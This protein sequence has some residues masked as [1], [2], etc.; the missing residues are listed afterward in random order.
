MRVDPPA[1]RRARGFTLTEI[2]VAVAILA[3]LLGGLL[4]PL[5]TQLEA[6]RTRDTQRLLEAAREAIVGFAVANG[7]LPCPARP[8]TAVGV[9]G[10]GTEEVT[11]TSPNRR[12][13]V[14]LVDVSSPERAVGVLPWVTLGLPEADA[15]GRRFTYVVD[16]GFADETS[17]GCNPIPN[18][19]SF[20]AQ[21]N[22]PDAGLE[23][24]TRQGL[25][26]TAT[27]PRQAQQVVAI[28]LSHG[29]N[30]YYGWQP[31]GTQ[32][33]SPS[34]PA[35]RDEGDNR[36]L[37]GTTWTASA[38]AIDRAPQREAGACSDKDGVSPL[39]EYDDQ[40]IWISRSLLVG[41][42]AA[43]GRL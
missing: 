16:H 22:M 36:V 23:V 30:G 10:A 24:R 40:V 34:D 31:N 35:A 17:S 13:H 7:R 6:A 11:G 15:W 18:A 42:M 37:P 43:A 39:C 12:C 20:C 1:A 21:F 4:V 25:G 27:L 28:T 29:R 26:A 38:L 19:P 9:A 8:D 14:D 41:R 32:T 5:S 33:P 2:A 3:L